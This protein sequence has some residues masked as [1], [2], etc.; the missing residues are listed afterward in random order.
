MPYEQA[1][2]FTAGFTWGLVVLPIILIV[3]GQNSG[4]P[5]L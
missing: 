1:M 5:E 2:A 4:P 3:I